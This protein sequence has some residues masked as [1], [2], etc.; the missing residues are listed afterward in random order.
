MGL[1]NMTKFKLDT[2]TKIE[3]GFKIPDGY[4]DSLYDRLDLT[5][6]NKEEP[7]VIS[8]SSHRKKLLYAVAAVLV[9][10]VLIPLVTNAIQTK[11]TTTISNESIEDYLSSYQTVSN[12]DV[13]E[14]L[15]YEDIQSLEV[16]MKIDTKE[17]ETILTEN[18]YLEYFLLD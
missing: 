6:E 11:Q 12:H 17:I 1:N 2:H 5:I 8:F 18:D 15:T 7:K 13:V 14:L 9:L 16:D 10:A 4:F 3:T